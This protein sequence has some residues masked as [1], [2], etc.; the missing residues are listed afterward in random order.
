MGP[1]PRPEYLRLVQSWPRLSVSTK[2]AQL[3]ALRGGS[4]KA[5]PRSCG[6][7]QRDMVILIVAPR[8]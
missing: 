4:Q 8:P 3:M 1:M 5:H 6:V 7:L 2:Y